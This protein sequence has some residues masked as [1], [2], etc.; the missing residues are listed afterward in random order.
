[1]AAA[2]ITP[3]LLQTRGRGNRIVDGG[4]AAGAAHRRVRVAEA[5]GN[6][7]GNGACQ[8]RLEDKLGSIEVGKPDDLVVLGANLFKVKSEQMHTLP[9][10]LTVMDGRATHAERCG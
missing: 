3:P 4:D 6:A 1:M 10:L 5:L 8:L 9:V 7:T 2:A